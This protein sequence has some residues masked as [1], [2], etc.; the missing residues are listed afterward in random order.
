M[1]RLPII[2]AL[3][4]LLAGCSKSACSNTVVARLRAP[5]DPFTAVLFQRDCGATTGFSTQVGLQKDGEQLTGGGDVFRADDDHGKAKRGDWGGPWVEMQWTGP[6]QLRI[7][8]AR[9]ARIF[10]Q[11]RHV[12]GVEIS[13]EPVDR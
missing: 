1:P 6:G 5:A 8:Y 13:F 3:A 4:A 10:Q 11:E 7:R 12:Q 9:G 2:L